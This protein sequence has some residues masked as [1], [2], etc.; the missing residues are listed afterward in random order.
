MTIEVT[1]ENCCVCVKTNGEEFNL[2][3]G[4]VLKALQDCG[5][6]ICV[7]TEY[8]NE[9]QHKKVYGWFKQYGIHLLG[10][11]LN[12][13]YINMTID[14]KDVSAHTVSG[15]SSLYRTFYDWHA[16]VG[17]LKVRG[18]FTASQEEILYDEIRKELY[19]V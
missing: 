19:D 9:E 8:T 10:D 14:P 12:T 17:I 2:G 7:R 15:Y 6:N 5:H 1:F 11:N 3:A 13:K 16:V 4:P 18:V